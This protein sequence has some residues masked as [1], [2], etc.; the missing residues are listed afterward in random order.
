MTTNF[1]NVSLEEN[2]IRFA[3]IFEDNTFTPAEIQG[4]LLE[5]K[6]DCTKALEEGPAWKDRELK[7]KQ[8]KIKMRPVHKTGIDENRDGNGRT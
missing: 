1:R 6:K 2:A 4:F 3:E 7:A 5:R 8:E